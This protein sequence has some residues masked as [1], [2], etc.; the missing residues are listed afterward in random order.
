MSW[1]PK[2]GSRFLLLKLSSRF[3]QSCSVSP[4]L[5]VVVC[6]VAIAVSFSALAD[7]WLNL[8][9]CKRVSACRAE[10]K[11]VL[12]VAEGSDGSLCGSESF[13]VA[14]VWP[15]CLPALPAAAGSVT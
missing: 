3:C 10:M 6:L 8:Q 14:L 7:G 11:Q 9:K 1:L 5:P 4:G 13:L 12:P 2:R 15:G